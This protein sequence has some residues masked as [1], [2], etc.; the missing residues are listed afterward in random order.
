[1]NKKLLQLRIKK[2]LTQQQVSN[3]LGFKNRASVCHFESGKRK[4]SLTTLKKYAEV[5]GVGLGEIINF[6]K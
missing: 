1:M 2:G 3:L 5:F 4:P 6:N